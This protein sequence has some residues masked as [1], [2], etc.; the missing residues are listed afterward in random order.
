MLRRDLL[1]TAGV[2]RRRTRVR[3]R[4][5]GAILGWGR[6]RPRRRRAGA[7]AVGRASR[8]ARGPGAHA[9]RRRD[10]EAG[11]AGRAGGRQSARGHAPRGARAAC[12]PGSRRGSSCRPTTPPRDA[13]ARDCS[14]SRATAHRARDRPVVARC[15]NFTDGGQPLVDAAFLAQAILRAPA[16]ALDA[17]STHR[18]RSA[19]DRAR[20][21]RRARITPGFN[22]WLLF[23]AM[24]EAALAGARRSRG[25]AMRVDYALRQHE[26][27]YKGDGVY[28]DGPEFHWDYYNSFVIQP[29]LLDVLDVVRRRAAGVEGAARARVER[30]RGAT[31]RS[32]SGSSRPTAA[33]RPSAD[34]SR[35]AAARSSCW[36]RWRCGARCPTACRP[37]RCAAR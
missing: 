23:S 22:N 34:R 10:A 25:I 26:Q 5:P 31:P 9:P 8:A 32:R 1:K 12:S 28:G 6:R 3:T 18:T 35:I 7:R 4:G 37:R 24:V 11:D 20:S 2:A 30:A 36:R 15:L 14:R 29:M 16:R 27:W 19:T 17:T 13:S 21:S 33:S